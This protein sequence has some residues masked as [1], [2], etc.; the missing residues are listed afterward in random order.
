M[1][2]SS[3]SWTLKSWKAHKQHQIGGLLE[4]FARRINIGH[5]SCP[6]S[7]PVEIDARDLAFGARLEIRIAKQHRQNRRLRRSL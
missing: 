6:F 5:P 4:F 2:E 3:R 1:P 7:G